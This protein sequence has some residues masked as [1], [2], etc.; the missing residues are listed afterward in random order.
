ML[1]KFKSTIVV[2]YF[3]FAAGYCC[4]LSGCATVAEVDNVRE[5]IS[6]LRRESIEIRK[7]ISEIREGAVS[8]I[9]EKGKALTILRE[10]QVEIL[11]QLSDISI[12]LQLLTGRFEENKYFIEKTLKDS[13]SEKDQIKTQIAIT[14]S[15]IK[16]I[17]DQIKALEDQIKQQKEQQKET[18][19]E[20]LPKESQK[21]EPKD[22]IKMYEE[23]YNTFKEK[24]YKEAREKFE[25][26][27]KEFP[28]DKLSGNAQFWIAETYYG[29]KDFENA[30]LSYE[31]LLKKYPKSEKVPAALLKQGF[32]FIEIGDK[33]TGKVIL[34]KLI[35]LY[36]KS[37][38][39]DLAKRKIKEIDKKS[40]K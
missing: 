19:T 29:E 3:F 5:D 12:K 26:F 15:R 34:E 23:I 22:K 11:S 25:V 20:E 2:G 24:K 27:I 30:I 35:E 4:L 40:K 18:K 17:K 13:I 10:S 39:T 38:E 32:S 14:E 28:E 31:T 37:N 6:G 36:P 9:Q 21:E 1:R 33:K 8:G 7:E 16:E